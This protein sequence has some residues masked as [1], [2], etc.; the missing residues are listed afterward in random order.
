MGC[1]IQSHRCPNGDLSQIVE[2]YLRLGFDFQITQLPLLQDY[3]RGI[4]REKLA[5]MDLLEGDHLVMF[6][7]LQHVTEG[8]L[9]RVNATYL[10]SGDSEF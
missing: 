10:A 3:F 8:Y 6:Y 4:F 2:E 7:P 1:L 5:T 9:D